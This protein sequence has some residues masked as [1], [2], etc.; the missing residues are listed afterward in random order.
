MK[1]DLSRDVGTQS[2]APVADNYSDARWYLWDGGFVALGR[3]QGTVAAHSHHA[4]QLV[5]GFD[6]TTSVRGENGEWH[7]GHAIIV[8]PDVTHSFNSRDALGALIFV[9]PESREGIWLCSTLTEDI[10]IVPTARIAHWIVEMRKFM[11][12]PF[13]SLD[14]GVLIRSCVS[15][16]CTGAPPARRFDPRVNIVLKQI[17]SSDNLRISLDKAAATV[18][19][20]PG[21]FAH[22]FKQQVGLPFRRYILWRKLIRALLAMG[23]EGSIA[24]AAQVAD[25]ADAAHLTRTFSQMFGASPSLVMR[26]KFYEIPHPYD[27]SHLPDNPLDI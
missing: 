1:P 11:D 23:R 13:E 14:I 9:E 20:S 7:L 12:Q 21:R 17:K 4:I 15:A 22:L 6:G 18:F 8:K 26:G 2:A 19:L 3:S 25:F 5:F 16:L 24:K 10:T 27:L